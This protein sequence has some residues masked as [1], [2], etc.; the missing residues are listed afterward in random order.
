MLVGHFGGQSIKL[1]FTVINGKTHTDTCVN[2]QCS[3]IA[4]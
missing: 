4:H 2:G 1:I 3:N